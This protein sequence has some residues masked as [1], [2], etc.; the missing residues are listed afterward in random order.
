MGTNAIMTAEKG[1]P[2]KFVFALESLYFYKLF[3]HCERSE[4]IPSLRAQRSNP[5]IASEAKQ[6][7]HCE[8]SP[9]VIASEA[10]QSLTARQRQGLRR[11][12]ALADV[13]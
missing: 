6:P 8:A 2:L 5:V 4:A 3:R 10:K 1:F 12:S 9:L 11:R 7:R 13:V